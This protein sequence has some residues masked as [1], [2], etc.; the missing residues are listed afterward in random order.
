MLMLSEIRR[1]RLIDNENRTTPIAD[2]SIDL[3]GDDYPPVKQVFFRNDDRKFVGLDWSEISQIDGRKNQIHVTDL[4]QAK[5]FSEEHLAREV[6]LMRDVMDAL[7]LDLHN[8]RATRAN[9]LC[10]EER[11]K[12]LVLSGADVSATAILRRLSLNFWRSVDERNLYDWRNVEFLRGDPQA[13]RNGAGYYLR[14]AKLAPGE[15]AGFIELIPYLH[16]AELIV[17]LPD[18]LAAAVLELV[19]PA[20]QLQIFEELDD[21]QT[22]KMF[23][24]LAPETSVNIIK[25]LNETEAQRILKTLPF[26]CALKIIELLRYPEGT[27]GSLMTNN[28]VFVP[29]DL[30]IDEACDYLSEQLKKAN[31]VYFIYVVEDDKARKLHGVISLRNLFTA[32]PQDK[33]ADIMDAYVSVLSPVDEAT[34]A[35]Y[36]LI[37]SHLAAMPVVNE[38]NK[39]LGA[40]TIDAAVSA[41]APRNWRNQAPRIFS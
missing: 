40:L 6:L 14:I 21:E 37:D 23:T 4:H 25:Q 30:T 1:F 13:V 36:R 31:F 20:R 22:R 28:I 17:L 33:I 3:I 7:V 9:D 24:L 34:A 8:R 38:E 41:V 35:S 11:G 15:I 16:G 39:L 26:D 29:I 27:V 12:Q 18:E 10:L 5:E 32:K 2:L 19:S